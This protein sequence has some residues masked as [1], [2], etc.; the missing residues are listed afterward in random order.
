MRC[1]LP[2]NASLLG[3]VLLV[4]LSGCG[5]RAGTSE[6]ESAW[7][8]KADQTLG[9]ALSSLGTAEL[10]LDSRAKGRLTRAYVVVAMR[11]AVKA[12]SKENEKFLLVQPPAAV[13]HDSDRTVSELER[14]ASVLQHASVAISGG[15]PAARSR[16]LREVRRTAEDVSRLSDEIKP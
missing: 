14:A 15:D 8:T 11:D 7:R 12:V 16:A 5:L 4:A 9:T 3:L 2:M 10:L 6:S 1:R 13:G